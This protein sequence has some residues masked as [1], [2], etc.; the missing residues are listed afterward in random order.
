[1]NGDDYQRL[2][3]PFARYK[4]RVYPFLGIAEEAG[5]VA[6]LAA[7]ALRKYG[8]IEFIDSEKVKDEL[9]DVLWNVALCAQECGLTMDSIMQYNIDKLS[10]R[11]EKGTIDAVER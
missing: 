2:A 11:L 5:E 4:S 3:K 6:G 7:K 1:M 9:G 8:S 10:G